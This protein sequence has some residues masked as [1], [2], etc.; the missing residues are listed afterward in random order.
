MKK[1]LEKD[2]DKNANFIY[3]LQIQSAEIFL[4]NWNR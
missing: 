1:S 2:T 3:I 4:A